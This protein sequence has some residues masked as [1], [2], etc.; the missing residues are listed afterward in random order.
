MATNFREQIKAS[1][2][3]ADE[4]PA[5][6]LLN[7]EL[8]GCIKKHK[9]IPPYHIQF[10]PT[11]RCNL[12]CDFCSCS[13]EDR[14]LEMDKELAIKIIDMLGNMTI[15]EINHIGPR[16]VT[17]TGG[18]DPLMHP[19]IQQIIEAFADNMIDIGLVTNGLKL[20]DA[21]DCLPE[22][23]WC[24][25][26]HSDDRPF[27]PQYAKQ[28]GKVVDDCTS[29]DWSFSY[30][31]SPNPSMETIHAIVDF[32]NSHAFKHVRLVADLL[33]YNKVDLRKVRQYLEFADVL[34]NKVI[35]QARNAPEH[36]GHCYIGCLKPV[37]GADAKVY[38]CCGV[39]Y[40]LKDP[41]RKLA[42]QFCLGNALD[43]EKI[44]E[45]Y[46]AKPF[47]GSICERCYYGGYNRVLQALLL[48]VEHGDF[49]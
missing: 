47:D 28:L 49:V 14:N 25:I 29:V 18:G 32:A 46:S 45:R 20:C 42:D 22:L 15:P 48:E 5:K 12:R 19:D 6:L 8:I 39:Q 38:P 43:L 34:D 24:R 7:D 4:I 17:I 1:Y 10:I 26:S 11:N 33:Q 30:V 16:T 9:L 3:S 41:S 31:V 13:E 40:A 36:G 35:Y 2:S 23:E 37:I 27:S 44:A 21:V